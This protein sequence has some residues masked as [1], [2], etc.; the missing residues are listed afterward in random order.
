MLN[1]CKMEK[2]SNIRFMTLRHQINS[3]S[4]PRPYD[5]GLLEC[6]RQMA[7]QTIGFLASSAVTSNRSG[8]GWLPDVIPLLNEIII[9]Q[10]S[11]RCIKNNMHLGSKTDQK[12]CGFMGYATDSLHHWHYHSS[13]FTAGTNRACSLRQNRIFLQSAW[14]LGFQRR[15]RSFTACS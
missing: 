13:H 10:A 1:Q 3:G 12:Q 2:T 8:H 14:Q 4:L 5:M 6:P 7:Q 9:P 15:H 11:K